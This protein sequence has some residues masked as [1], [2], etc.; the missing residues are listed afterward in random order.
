M[1]TAQ[2]NSEI[3]DRIAGLEALSLLLEGAF[4]G[5]HN[6]KIN[7]EIFD[8]SSLFAMQRRICGELSSLY[9]NLMLNLER[10]TK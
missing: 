4:A 2:L 8:G 9:S 7:S 5:S 10:G 1:N 6:F 3:S